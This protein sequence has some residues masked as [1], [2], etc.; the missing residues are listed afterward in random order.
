[1]TAES[2]GS[3]GPE[4]SSPLRVRLFRV[5]DANRVVAI[6]ADSPGA[7][8][9]S[10]ASYQRLPTQ[11][12]MLAFVTEEPS[13]ITGFLV[14]QAFE[15][16]AEILNLAVAPQKRRQGYATALLLAALREFQAHDVREVHLEVRES[17]TAAIAFYNTHGF[18]KSGLRRGYYRA[19]D[20]NAVTMLRKIP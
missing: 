3:F 4:E 9:W 5:E 14:A 17:N 8:A 20:E 1:M 13:G 19:P 16:Q 18:V 10:V 11:S 12:G 15:K 6:A 7:A 2:A